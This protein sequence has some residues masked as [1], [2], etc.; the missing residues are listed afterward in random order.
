MATP[1]HCDY[2]A[3]PHLADVLVNRLDGSGTLAA[4]NP[5][6]LDFMRAMVEAVDEAEAA[7]TA[8]EAAARLEGAN[9][10][11]DPPTSAESSAAADPAAEPPLSGPGEPPE[12]EVAPSTPDP[13]PPRSGRS[14][15][16]SGDPGEVDPTP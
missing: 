10:P 6:Y 2:G 8:A 9:A 12:T 15:P 16:V 4:C 11:D 5:H 7:A 3:E 13:I 14:R 1:I